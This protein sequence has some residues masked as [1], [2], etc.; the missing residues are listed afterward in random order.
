MNTIDTKAVAVF[1]GKVVRKDLTKVVKGNAVVPTYVLEYLLGQYCSSDDEA[2]VQAGVES[3]RDIIAKNFVHRDE[4]KL[5]QSTIK[6]NEQHRIIDKLSAQLNETSGVYECSFSNLGISKVAVSAHIIKQHPKLLSGGGVW[7]I[8]SVS[9]FLTEDKKVSPWIINNLKPIQL[10]ACDIDEYKQLR[11]Q[12]VTDE[13][14]DLLLQSIGLNP[15]E[16]DRRSK[17]LQ[18]TRLIP[19]CENNYNLIELGPKGTGK[20]HIYSELSPHGILISGGEVTKAKLFVSNSSKRGEIGL[21]GY[22]DCIAYD[23]FAGKTKKVDT[24]LI[25]LLK[26]YMANRS[27]SRG[28]DVIG[29]TASMVFV[30]NTD[31]PVEHMVKQSDLFDALSPAYRQ[32][33]F[34]DRFHAYLPGWE[35]KKLRNEMFTTG[36]GFIVDYLA[37]VLKSL[38][39]E[40]YTNHFKELF[41]LSDSI[42]TRDLDGIR[43]TYSGLFKVLYPHGECTEEEAREILE[44]CIECRMRVKHQ[45]LKIDQTF[46]TVDFSYTIKRTK[47][48]KT[49]NPLEEINLGIVSTS[50]TYPEHE[51]YL[52]SLEPLEPTAAIR[53]YFAT[54]AVAGQVILRSNQK[55]VTYEALFTPYLIG[56]KRIEVTDPYIRFPYQLRNFIEF[57]ALVHKIRE[58]GDEVQLI[59]NTATDDEFKDKI[60]A[61]L[62][63][64]ADSLDGTGVLFSFNLIGDLHDRSIVLD[65]GW[66]IVL[67]RGLDIW[68]K[69]S[70]MFDI[71]EKSQEMRMCKDCEITVVKV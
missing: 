9:Y 3:V 5:I 25:D 47:E 8:V 39:K 27:F 66:K 65:T 46:E 30:G 17:L 41:E 69:T 23:E 38:R 49:V 16:F 6:E 32:S 51:D 36:Y 10:S 4:A 43:K 37:E 60:R 33:A 62:D 70:G 71:A 13:W 19:F 55:G 61:D 12:F 34:L 42:T 63:S 59:L 15:E 14:M 40:D 58:I 52:G 48:K 31:H 54:R 67:G 44:F 35:V 1:S 68:Q 64:L 28:T 18:L 57:V 24:G 45:L 26:N 29:A 20:S 2:I 22:W 7:C 50:P 53:R 56:A 11:K 21:I